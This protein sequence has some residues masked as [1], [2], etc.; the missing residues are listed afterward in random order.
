[1]T[2]A[3]SLSDLFDPP[4]DG[5]CDR[6][7]EAA[8]AGRWR[9]VVAGID[10][11]GRGPLAGPVVTAAVV[12]TDAPLPEELGDSKG[13]D[14]ATRERLFAILCRDHIVAVASASAGRIDAM[15]IRGATLWAMTR[16]FLHLPVRPVGVLVDGRDVPAEILM[17]G[18]RGAAIVKGDGCVAAIAAAS[19]VAK[20][21]RD[22]M[23]TAF[24]ERF[25]AYGFER[26]MGYGTP[27]HKRALTLHG[28]CPV[29]RR[30]F[31]PVREW[32]A[33]DAAE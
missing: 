2:P 8:Y 33:A 10:E 29:H 22:R 6:R 18:A 26:H 4:T 32:T 17:R 21:T 7:V 12:L 25:P 28:P 23:M 5:L 14:A 20:V 15:N 13:L 24:A 1:M 31:A 16:A 27:E 30:S 9:G 3:D 19:I 11:A